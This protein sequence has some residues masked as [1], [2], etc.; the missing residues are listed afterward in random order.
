MDF[1]Y[2]VL[3]IFVCL[4]VWEAKLPRRDNIKADIRWP[5][6]FSLT[7]LTLIIHFC[8][9]NL[10]PS[11]FS[12]AN[13]GISSLF[14]Y[15]VYVLLSIILLDLL[16]YL[17]HRISHYYQFLWKLHKVHHSDTE[18]D[19]STNFRHHPFEYLWGGIVIYAFIMMLG[20]DIKTLILYSFIAQIIQL[21]HHSN[22]YIPQ[23][24]DQ[25]LSKFLITPNVHIIHHSMD[26]TQSNS[27]FGTVFSFWDRMFSTYL[28]P[29]DIKSL[30]KFGIKETCNDRKH[31]LKTLL[32]MPFK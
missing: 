16:Y 32:L 7:L 17:L 9:A 24:I 8:I 21:W 28:E 26:I 11:N 30:K 23:D 27:N 22:I 25:F 20:I 12:F 29:N 5:A 15:T 10:F 3:V 6:N 31:T 18:I 14:P 1:N 2:F 4:L 19:I 13:E